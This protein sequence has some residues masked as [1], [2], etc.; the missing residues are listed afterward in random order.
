V[1]KAAAKAVRSI[2]SGNY[3]A[4]HPRPLTDQRCSVRITVHSERAAPDD[5]RREWHPSFVRV[6]DHPIRTSVIPDSP[7]FEVIRY[8]GITCCGLTAFSASAWSNRLRRTVTW[9]EPVS[10]TLWH[11][12]HPGER[13]NFWYGGLSPLICY[14]R[15]ALPSLRMGSCAGGASESLARAWSATTVPPPVPARQ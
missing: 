5:H 11:D 7:A 12:A 13:A 3:N 15:S 9:T 1:S 8:G 4:R 10:A 2:M 14:P 6:P